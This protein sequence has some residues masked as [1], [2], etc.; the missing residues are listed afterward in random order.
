MWSAQHMYNWILKQRKKVAGVCTCQNIVSEKIY[1][2]LFTLHKL[3]EEKEQ[4]LTTWGNE[5]NI[6]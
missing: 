4:K 6:F 3:A 2:L 1:I 5:R